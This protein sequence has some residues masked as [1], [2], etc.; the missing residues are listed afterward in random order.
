MPWRAAGIFA[1]LALIVVSALVAFV[2]LG[3]LGAEN[4]LG[5][6]IGAS[7]EAPPR[8]ATPPIVVV[9]PL[10]NLSGNAQRDYFSDGV[11]EDII[12]A[13]GRY[14]GLR[15][16]SHNSV[17]QFKQR[18][19]GGHV[20][21]SELGARYIVKGSV[22]ESGSRLRV[23]VELSDAQNNQVLWSQQYGRD[24]Q[25]IFDIQ[26]QIVRNI[27]GA[28]A[29]RVSHQEQQRAAAAVPGSLQAYDLVLRARPL[30]ASFDRAANHEARELLAKAQALAPDYAEVDV[31]FAAAE[32][33]RANFGWTE[34]PAASLR[35]A[36]QRARRA[37]TLNDAGAH[38][39]AHGQL[40]LIHSMRGE[41]ER[42]LIE[43]ARA[44][45]INP[46]DAV[47]FDA[48]GTTLVW[49]GQFEAA[50]ASLETAF[51]FNPA[52]RSAG[53]GF[54]LGL[55]HYALGQYAQALAAADATIARYPQASFVYAMRAATLA[56][57]GDL[58]AARSAAAQ[59]RRL[60]PFFSPDEFG[61][62]FV[63][64]KHQAQL[65][66]GLRAAGL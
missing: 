11:T 33:N 22:R 61:N 53:S 1:G 52:G 3:G 65:R 46:S 60:A 35:R 27:V 28:L 43:S 42:A 4:E 31:V 25:D 41:F 12:G 34:D 55:A 59:L 36:E 18:A 50:I 39:R 49:M 58:D 51:R 19:G 7:G 48:Q 38:A 45:E 20:I 63:D 15:V 57:M 6:P 5:W 21:Q 14:S 47:A 10:T 56:Q 29:V 2:G 9:L 32:Y 8:A 17:Q 37:L 16:I 13:L 62:R 66:E 26:D 54:S 30:V 40:G 44:I 64:P 23:A 24:G